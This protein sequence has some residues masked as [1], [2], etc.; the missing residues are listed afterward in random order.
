MINGLKREGFFLLEILAYPNVFIYC[1][2]N[3]KKE[4]PISAWEFPAAEEGC[5]P[6]VEAEIAAVPGGGERPEF[7]RSSTVDI[8]VWKTLWRM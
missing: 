5:L 3:T 6:A 2:C 7:F 1:I 4:N 8:T